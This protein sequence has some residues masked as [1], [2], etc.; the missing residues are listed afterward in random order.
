MGGLLTELLT[1]RTVV[2]VGYSLNDWNFRRLYK[3][4][5]KDMGPYSERA[6]FVSPFGADEADVKELGLITLKTSGVKFL[7]ELKKSNLGNCFIDDSS[8]DRVSDYHDEILY[9]DSYAKK[10]VSHKQYPSVFYCWSFHDGASDACSRISNRRGAGEYSSRQYVRSQI[11]SY[12]ALAEQSWNDERY[13]D[14]AY[15]EGYL[16]PLYIMLD[17]RPDEDGEPYPLFNTA[18]FYFVYGAD[19]D[20][21]MRTEDDFDNAVKMSNRRAPKQRRVARE[22]LAN[23]PAGMIMEHSP[24]LSGLRDENEYVED[25]HA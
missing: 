9:A 6:Y 24:F 3:A 12:E 14:H 10:A 21:L 17:D 20:L 19:D 5:L 1:T 23:L 13:W 16:T 18:P 11:K 4:L 15:I 8:Y 22:R 25:E 2:F 7:K